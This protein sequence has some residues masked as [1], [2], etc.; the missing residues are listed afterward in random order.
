MTTQVASLLQGGPISAYNSSPDI[1]LLDNLVDPV[2]QSNSAYLNTPGGVCYQT[3]GTEVNSTVLR[4]DS[5]PIGTGESLD[6]LINNGLETQDSFGKWVNCTVT[7]SPC[8]MGDPVL[9]SSS[10]SGQDSFTS[11]EEIFSI[12]EVSPAWA[13]STEKTK[14]LFSLSLCFW[15]DRNHPCCCCC[16]CTHFSNMHGFRLCYVF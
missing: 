12:T 5:S 2:A 8:S 11:P 3:P 13:Y 7:E 10:S 14:V 6:L 4:E 1:S 9:E 15:V 16:C